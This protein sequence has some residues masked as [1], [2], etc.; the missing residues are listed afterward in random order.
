MNGRRESGCHHRWLDWNNH[1]LRWNGWRYG[2]SS[3]R[4]SSDEWLGR[5]DGLWRNHGLRGQDRLRWNSRWMMMDGRSS[6]SDGRDERLRGNDW[7]RWN[8]WWLLW[9]MHH[10][11]V[12]DQRTHL[13]GWCHTGSPT[14]RRQR[15][16][17]S[18][19]NLFGHLE[20]TQLQVDQ[21][22]GDAKLHQCHLA[23][24]V[25]VRETPEME[26]KRLISALIRERTTGRA[27]E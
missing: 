24:G 12:E 7:G 5:D 20:S 1:R 15:A 16:E 10:G 6:G 14:R 2:G 11:S 27:T 18:G 17:Q 4:L 8:R 9:M 13:A 23:V 19:R 25:S 26:H 21:L 3:H 22:A